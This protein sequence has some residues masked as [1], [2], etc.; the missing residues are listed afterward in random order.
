M[1]AALVDELRMDIEQSEPGPERDELERT[2]S[3]CQELTY[4]VEEG[5][6]GIIEGEDEEYY[7]YLKDDCHFI[8]A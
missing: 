3:F 1:E 8:E 4:L 5:F 2:L 6:I 7:L